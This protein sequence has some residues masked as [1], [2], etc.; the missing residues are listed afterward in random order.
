MTLSWPFWLILTIPVVVAF[1]LRPLPSRGLTLLR[2]PDSLVT[3]VGDLRPKR[4]SSQ[5]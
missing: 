5:P 1:W 4:E 2:A 3:V